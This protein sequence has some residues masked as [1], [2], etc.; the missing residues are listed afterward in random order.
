LKKVPRLLL[1]GQNC[2]FADRKHTVLKVEVKPIVSEKLEEQLADGF[3]V[4]S[5]KISVSIEV[6]VEADVD[7]VEHSGLEVRLVL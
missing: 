4:G 5:S 2:S 7:S 6:F 3:S 1:F